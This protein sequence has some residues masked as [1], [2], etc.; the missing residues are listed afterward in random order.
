M[1]AKKKTNRG[2][3][4]K[5]LDDLPKG[6]KEKMLSLASEGASHVEIQVEALGCISND[7]WYRLIDEEP[8]FSETVKRCDK[9]CESWWAKLGRQGANGSADINPTTWIFNMKNRFGW[10]DKQELSGNEDQPLVP[11]INVKLP[12][13][14]GD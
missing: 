7:L 10:R 13:N 1:A 9:L 11:V 3:P 14:S 5:Q 2:R 8:E 12:Q 4:K 6:W